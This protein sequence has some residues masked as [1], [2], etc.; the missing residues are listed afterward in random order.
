M[1]AAGPASPVRL[2]ASGFTLVELLIGILVLAIVSAI[3][4]PSFDGFRARQRL[5]GAA[6]NLYTDLQYARSEAVQRNTR[7]VV[8]FS[9]G[10][11]WCYGLRVDDDGTGC[12]CSTAGSCGLKTVSG[13][14]YP[15][16]TM[17]AAAF[18]DG[19]T[20][21]LFDPRRGQVLDEDGAVTEGSVLL[22]GADGDEIQLELN[23]IGRVRLCSPDGAVGGYP[24]CAP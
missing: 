10:S 23:A 8:N 7:V 13:A 17:S 6:E 14:A 19:D 1:A 2:P 4:L 15:G 3:A 16:V 11:S 20:S 9:T 21:F 5:K 24:S 12:D 18:G 22:A